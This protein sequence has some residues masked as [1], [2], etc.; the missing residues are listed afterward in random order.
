MVLENFLRD[1]DIL[2]DRVGKSLHERPDA[3]VGRKMRVQVVNASIVEDLT[4][5]ALNL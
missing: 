2:W 3:L 1:V 4:G 5:Y